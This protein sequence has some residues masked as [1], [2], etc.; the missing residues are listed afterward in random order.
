MSRKATQGKSALAPEEALVALAE[1]WVSAEEAS[2]ARGG[3]RAQCVREAVRVT[4]L[5]RRF[6]ADAVFDARIEVGLKSGMQPAQALVSWLTALQ[7]A[8]WLIPLGSRYLMLLL[9][10]G[11]PREI[12]SAWASFE[13]AYC[14]VAERLPLRSSCWGVLRAVAQAA[15]EGEEGTGYLAS[16]LMR[17]AS[18]PQASLWEQLAGWGTPSK[19]RARYGKC[20]P[21]RRTAS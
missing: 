1:R 7:G 5:A 9:S 14:T 6:L 8:Q 12:N 4:G 10:E 11:E 19:D 15:V 13:A 20:S 16:V 3:M 2:P 17:E 18:Q 21:G